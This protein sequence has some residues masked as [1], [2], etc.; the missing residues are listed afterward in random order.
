M[1]AVQHGPCVF[2][3]VLST[4]VITTSSINASFSGILSVQEEKKKVT[5]HS[6]TLIKMAINLQH[7]TADLLTQASRL[8][9][10]TVR[11]WGGATSEQ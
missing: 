7:F 6:R 2:C 10:F 9:G 1:E 5:L 3:T 4:N 8:K 11:F